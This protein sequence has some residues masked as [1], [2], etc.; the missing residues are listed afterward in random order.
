MEGGQR[1]PG[2]ERGHGELLAI[3]V[4]DE[5]GKQLLQPP[6]EERIGGRLDGAEVGERRRHQMMMKQEDDRELGGVVEQLRGGAQEIFLAEDTAGADQAAGQVRR[7]V[8]DDAGRETVQLRRHHRGQEGVPN[9]VHERP[10]RSGVV[11]RAE[12]LGPVRS[13]Q[14]ALATVVVAGHDHGRDL[15]PEGGAHVAEEVAEDRR[16]ERQLQGGGVEHVPGDG[17]QARVVAG[18]AQLGEGAG[19]GG[20]DFRLL[21]GTGAEVQI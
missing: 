11:E 2:A 21:G 14:T 10:W 18:A 7:V 5:I 20:E 3:G 8:G 6:A 19:E 16:R 13:D 4:G 9:P 1:R 12:Q 17:D 15:G